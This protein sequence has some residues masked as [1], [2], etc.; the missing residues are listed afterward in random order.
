MDYRDII[1]MEPGKRSGKPCVRGLRIAV[2]DVLEY[3]ASGRAR[4]IGCGKGERAALTFLGRSPTIGARLPPGLEGESRRER[5]Y[6]DAHR[7]VYAHLG[8]AG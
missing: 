4:F 3:L 8:S 5:I 6:L 2:S 1:T 7:A